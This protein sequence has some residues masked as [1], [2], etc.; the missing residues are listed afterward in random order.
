MNQ[1]FVFRACI[2]AVALV[3]VGSV[4]AQ[5][6]ISGDYIESRSADV[7]TGQCFANGE[8]GLSGDQAILA[9][10]IKSGSWNGVKL[11]GF[12]VVAAVKAS[13][14]LGDPYAD[15][16]PAKSVLIID[17][18]ANAKEREALA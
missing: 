8:V 1:M 9:W 15:P 16:Y 6:K 17:Q 13:A 7:Y 4:V 10:H 14:T 11:D 3:F 18:R 5:A 2:F 12:S